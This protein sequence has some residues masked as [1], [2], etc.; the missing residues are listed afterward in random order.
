MPAFYQSII[1]MLSN[2]IDLALFKRSIDLQVDKYLNKPIEAILLFNS[3]EV[4]LQRKLK[5][6]EFEKQKELLKSYQ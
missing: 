4:F 5:D 6:I 1:L 3:V 2:D